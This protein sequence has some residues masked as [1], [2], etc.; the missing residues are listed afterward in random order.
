MTPK[1]TQSAPRLTGIPQEAADEVRNMA[2]IIYRLEARI[3][4][5]EGKGF[6]TVEQANQMY[7][8]PVMARE[9]SANGS[10]PLNVVTVAGSTIIQAQPVARR[11]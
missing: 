3:R 2:Q 8:P 5:M 7:S 4:N 1:R 11:K 10:A 9:L 6:L